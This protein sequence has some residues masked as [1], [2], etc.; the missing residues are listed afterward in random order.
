VET[1]LLGEFGRG[2][3]LPERSISANERGETSSLKGVSSERAEDSV[4]KLLDTMWANQQAD[5]TRCS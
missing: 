5:L 2:A 4:A 1:G 3:R